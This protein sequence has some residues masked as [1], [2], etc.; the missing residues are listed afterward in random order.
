MPWLQNPSDVACDS[1]SRS[2]SSS[3]VGLGRVTR[4][5]RGISGRSSKP[6][7]CTAYAVGNE[8]CARAS[9][10]GVWRGVSR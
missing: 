4:V 3:S 10:L 9:K 2:V 6:A 1:T 5:A 7:L 8:A